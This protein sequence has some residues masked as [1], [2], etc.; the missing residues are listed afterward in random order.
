VKTFV[1]LL[2][3]Y[4]W[5]LFF[6]GGTVLAVIGAFL[7]GV[8]DFFLDLI[9]GRRRH[10]LKVEKIRARAALGGKGEEKPSSGPCPH[11]PRN[12]KPVFSSD[13]ENLLAWLCT[14][15]DT[16]LDKDW[17]VLEEDL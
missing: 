3:E 13:G 1:E 12:V 14:A 6:F 9:E 5:L 15:C 2:G 4:W 17:A 8:R 11:R 10:Q 16:R 7:E